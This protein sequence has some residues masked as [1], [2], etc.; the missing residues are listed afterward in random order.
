MAVPLILL[1]GQGLY[2]IRKDIQSVKNK[3][4]YSDIV[5]RHGC[6]LITRCE[7]PLNR[8]TTEDKVT[9]IIVTI[10]GLLLVCVSN[11]ICFG[12]L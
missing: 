12:I 10:I 11:F 5:I 2:R 7:M 8:M 4:Q 3:A 1:T 6:Y 9:I